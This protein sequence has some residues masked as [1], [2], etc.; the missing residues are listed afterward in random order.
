MR[1]P[2]IGQD[3]YSFQKW[4]RPVDGDRGCIESDAALSCVVKFG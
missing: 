1:A 3:V 2:F 4:K